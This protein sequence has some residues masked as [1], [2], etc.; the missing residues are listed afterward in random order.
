M[1]DFTLFHVVAGPPDDWANMKISLF[2][3]SRVGA[4]LGKGDLP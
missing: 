2:S 3:H 4:C 1:D